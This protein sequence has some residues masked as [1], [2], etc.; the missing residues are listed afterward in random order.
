MTRP[1]DAQQP[2]EAPRRGHLGRLLAST[3]V[4]ITGQGMVTAATPLLAAS[5][6]RDPLGVSVI[7][8]ATYAAWIVVGLPAGVWVDRWPRRLTMVLSDLFRAL[9]LGGLAAAVLGHH[10]SLPTLAVAVFLIGSAACFFDPAA[11]AAIPS[12]VGRDQDGLARANSRIW[13]LDILGRS[14]VGPPMGAALFALGASIPFGVNALTFVLS[15]VL[16]SGLGRLEVRPGPEPEQHPAVWSALAEGVRFL[17]K[18]PDL[19]ALTI[20]MGSYNLA[21]NIAYATLVLFAQDKLHLSD[22]GFGFLLA[23]QA[24]GGLIGAWLAPRLATKLRIRAI[25]A[26]GLIA[27][28]VGWLVV[29]IVATPVAS[30]AALALIGLASM[31][32]T[33]IGGTARQSLTPD[34]LLGRIS[35]GTRVVGVGT[36]AIGALLGGSLAQATSLVDSL[37]AAA[38]VCAVAG[39]AF[40]FRAKRRIHSV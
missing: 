21:Y 12:I 15:A 26:T 1:V 4:S 7:T 36:A 29:A 30:G 3:G 31:V 35:S 17:W 14:L 25:Y 32:V 20:G 2:A 39:I 28:G 8:A 37:I 11:Q 18:H 38:T 33:V 13:M 23:T 27:Q 10:A 9:V 5:L 40:A 22:R 19:R 24:V 34:H 16:L 6:T